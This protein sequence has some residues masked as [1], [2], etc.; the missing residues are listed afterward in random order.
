MLLNDQI[1]IR[2][3]NDFTNRLNLN[4]NNNEMLDEN[5]LSTIKFSYSITEL[6]K[7][8]PKLKRYSFI[9]KSDNKLVTY[10]NNLDYDFSD[11]K[12]EKIS[13]M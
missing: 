7:N 8:L 13:N 2:K 9:S 4:F 11:R 3:I 6:N 1:I 5:M 12:K 10:N